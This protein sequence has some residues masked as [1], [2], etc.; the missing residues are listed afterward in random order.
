MIKSVRIKNIALIETAEIEFFG[1]FNVLSG[2]TGS[3]KTVIINAINFALGAKAD[4]TLIRYGENYCETEVVFSEISS[5]AKSVL[6]ELSIDVDDDVVI[7]RKLTTEGRS[8]IRVNGVSVTLSMLK[9]LTLSLCD[10]YLYLLLSMK[11]FE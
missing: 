7:R 6:E 4:K 10:I 9:K 2:E 8:D 1:G 3:G 11:N 5:I